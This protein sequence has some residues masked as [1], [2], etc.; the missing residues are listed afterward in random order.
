MA[1]GLVCPVSLPWKL[2]D[3]E[4][5]RKQALSNHSQTIERLAE[6]GGLDPM[7]AVAILQGQSWPNVVEDE[8]KMQ[9]ALNYLAKVR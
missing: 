3:N 8:D 1:K 9:A 5:A 7:E 6:R 2:F 4:K